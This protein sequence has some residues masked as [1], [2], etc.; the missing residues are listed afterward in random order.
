[1]F[2]AYGV[3]PHQWLTFA[4]NEW[5]WTPT[6][7]LLGPG[8]ILEKVL[9]FSLDYEKLRDIVVSG[10][11]AVFLVA[12]VALWMH[13]QNRGKKQPAALPTSTYGRPLVRKN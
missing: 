11:Y 8:E 3:V 7:Q 4:N 9:P 10:I 13:W 2:W 5:Q 1:M 6:K 12:H